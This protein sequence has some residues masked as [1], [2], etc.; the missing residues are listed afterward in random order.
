MSKES[1]AQHKIDCFKVDI[2]HILDHIMDHERDARYHINKI[3][4]L[5]DRKEELETVIHKLGGV[6]DE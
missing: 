3:K 5:R 4:A 2:T 6:K 1:A